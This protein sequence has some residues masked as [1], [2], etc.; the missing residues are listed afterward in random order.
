[1]DFVFSFFTIPEL[2]FMRATANIIEKNAGIISRRTKGHILDNGD[3]VF[4][5]VNQGVRK[6]VLTSNHGATI[7]DGY[8]P[9]GESTWNQ[10]DSWK[11]DT[12]G[13]YSLSNVQT[14][15]G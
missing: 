1:M 11:S 15:Q 7:K 9:E 13:I 2:I 14:R 12:K 6:M 3:I 4:S 10:P 5:A 8:L